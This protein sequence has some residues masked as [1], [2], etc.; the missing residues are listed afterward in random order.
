MEIFGK[1]YYS[2]AEVAEMFGIS[3]ETWRKWRRKYGITGHY[4]RG[5]HYYAEETLRQLMEDNKVTGVACRV[6]KGE[7]K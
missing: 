1:K 4:M 2:S 7:G 5:T 3:V 6:K